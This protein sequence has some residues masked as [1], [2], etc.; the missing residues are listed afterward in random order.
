V[1]WKGI[2]RNG[3][4]G[5]G[6]FAAGEL[7]D[8]VAA[9]SFRIRELSDH[10]WCA[11]SLNTR[12]VI[13]L[14]T[15]LS[16]RPGSEDL[17]KTTPRNVLGARYERGKRY[18]VT[19]NPE[20]NASILVACDDEHIKKLETLLKETGLNVGRICCGTYILL[21]HA[22]SMTNTTRSNE[23]PGSFLYVICCLGSVCILVQDSDRWSELRSRTDVYENNAKPIIELVAP[24]KARV[25]PATEIVLACDGPVDGL[26]E[27][28][29]ALFESTKIRNLTEND[30]L[31]SLIAQ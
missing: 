25:N 24:F 13:S 19:H 22:L 16:R 30:L 26:V 7:K 14:E 23:K 6:D 5:E 10:N 3:K 12:Y 8:V 9:N 18:A 2:L 11:V 29:G 28:I 4:C 15:N 31:W 1:A 21:R 17:I 27:G 20:S